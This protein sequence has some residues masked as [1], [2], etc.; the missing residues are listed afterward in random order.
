MVSDLF[1]DVP[2]YEVVLPKDAEDES[3]DEEDETPPPAPDASD[4]DDSDDDEGDDDSAPLTR[5]EAKAL[6]KTVRDLS[7]AVGRAQS[8]ARAAQR[9]PDDDEVV[10]ELRQQN[11]DM[12]RL[13]ATVVEGIDPTAIDPNLR[14]RVI[15]ARQ[16][17]ESAEQRRQELDELR[18]ELGLTKQ[19]AKQQAQM[20]DL[21]EQANELTEELEDQI[22]AAGLDP[23]DSAL[24]PWKEWAELFK[25]EGPRAVRRAALAAIRTGSAADASGAR[26][27]QRRKAAGQTPRAA[28]AGRTKTDLDALTTGSLDDQMKALAKLTRS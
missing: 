10:G 18:A 25:A 19:S 22:V 15:Q 4:D 5:A 6:Q 11:S 17:L 23:D 2:E 20:M 14:S 16:E 3:E 28:A 27:E 7:T 21:Q 12:V 8:L 9:D 13:L 24:F 26:R 1:R